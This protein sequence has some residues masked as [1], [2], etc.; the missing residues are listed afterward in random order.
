MKKLIFIIAIVFSGMMG[1]AQSLREIAYMQ[2]GIQGSF[3]SDGTTKKVIKTDYGYIPCKVIRKNGQIVKMVFTI[4]NTHRHWG[5]IMGERYINKKIMDFRRGSRWT[6]IIINYKPVK[7]MTFKTESEAIEYLQYVHESLFIAHRSAKVYK[8]P[9]KNIYIVGK[10]NI[11][12][13]GLFIDDYTGRSARLSNK[14][15][16]IK[17]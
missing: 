8:K 2:T 6:D 1:Q 17:P 7:S 15:E 12:N 13:K 10:F 14:W 5:E 16:I 4:E 3:V 11:T 9:G